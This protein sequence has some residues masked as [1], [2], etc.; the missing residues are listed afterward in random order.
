MGHTWPV[1]LQANGETR[2]RENIQSVARAISL[3][4]CIVDNDGGLTLTELSRQT[5][6]NPSTTHRL[7][8]TLCE[9]NVLCRD[10]D[11]QRFV[12]GEL[13]LRLARSSMVVGGLTETGEILAELAERTGET[14]SFGVRDGDSVLILATAQSAQAL[15]FTRSG[16]SRVPLHSSAHGRALLAFA[17]GRLEPVVTRLEPLHADTEHTRIAR[18]DLLRELRTARKRGY[19]AVTDE[20]VLGVS[21]VAAPVGGPAV[22]GRVTARAAVCVEG[23]SARFTA[24]RTAELGEAVQDTARALQQI[25][26]SVAPPPMAH[27]APM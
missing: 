6:L 17:A 18:S 2:P 19:A 23:P 20:Y 11:N 10:L 21:G 8:Q 12:P 22:V 26:M 3:L 14:A 9:G 24:E 15:R 13:L 27:S 16:G 1:T 7:V 25:S 5:R 4:Q